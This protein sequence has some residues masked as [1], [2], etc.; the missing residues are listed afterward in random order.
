MDKVYEVI[1]VEGRA[2][3]ATLKRYFD[4]I[5]IEVGGLGLREDALNKLDILKDYLPLTALLDPDG[6]GRKIGERLKKRYPGLRL[7]SIGKK[8]LVS[9]DKKKLGIAYGTKPLLEEA[10]YFGGL[11]LS[12]LPST[13]T[14]GDFLFF[15]PAFYD[16]RLD[17]LDK[18]ILVE[19]ANRLERGALWTSE[20]D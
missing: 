12:R 10:L 17:N 6:P 11:S 20:H 2:D 8:G 9:K 13:Y 15:K 7:L 14:K 19:L 16:K 18:K 1:I 5:V 4:A 3:C